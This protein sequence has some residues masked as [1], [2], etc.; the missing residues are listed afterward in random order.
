M[1][2]IFWAAIP[3]TLAVIKTVNYGRWAGKQKNLRGMI[4]L[5]I[6]ALITVLFPLAVL[7]Y[8][9]NI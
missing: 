9:M 3:I 6:L 2:N 4:A 1:F 7:L 5:Y 8:N